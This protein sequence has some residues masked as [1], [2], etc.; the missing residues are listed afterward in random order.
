[1]KEFFIFE[2]SNNEI[3]VFIDVNII[4]LVRILCLLNFILIIIDICFK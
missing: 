4:I 2:K 3:Y 1:M